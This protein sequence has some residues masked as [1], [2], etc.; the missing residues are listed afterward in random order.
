MKNIPGLM[1]RNGKK[2]DADEL[3]IFKI[4]LN[5]IIDSSIGKIDFNDKS[6]VSRQAKFV[7]DE[8]VNLLNKYNIMNLQ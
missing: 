7:S 8:I 4:E 3:Y 6:S 5:S 2:L 1:T